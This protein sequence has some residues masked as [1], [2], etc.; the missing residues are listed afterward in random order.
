MI[1]DNSNIETLNQNLLIPS[2]SSHKNSFK[3]LHKSTEKYI[4][5]QNNEQKYPPMNMNITSRSHK[6]SYKYIHDIDKSNSRY[7]EKNQNQF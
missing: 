5:Y 2:R 4:Q 3:N 7:S 6:T 1:N